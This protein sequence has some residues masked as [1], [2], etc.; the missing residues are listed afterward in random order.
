MRKGGN[1]RD[2]IAKPPLNVSFKEKR[3]LYTTALRLMI[4]NKQ[5]F[6][7]K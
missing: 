1:G 4:M 6:F 3:F 7:G 5:F 2:I